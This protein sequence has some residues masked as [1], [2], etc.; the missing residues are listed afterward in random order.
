[1]P[2]SGKPYGTT[3]KHVG[4]HYVKTSSPGKASYYPRPDWL[5]ILVRQKPSKMSLTSVR[6]KRKRQIIN[7]TAQKGHPEHWRTPR[8]RAGDWKWKKNEARPLPKRRNRERTGSRNH[9][10]SVA[11]GVLSMRSLPGPCG[12]ACLDTRHLKAPG[13][14]ALVGDKLD[15]EAR[16]INLNRLSCKLCSCEIAD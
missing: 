12:L 8:S 14:A 1:M 4:T 7:G 13:R 15:R 2:C 6:Y 9:L 5:H 10:L 3:D 11:P 16:R